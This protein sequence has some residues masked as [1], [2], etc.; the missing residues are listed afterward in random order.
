[1]LHVAKPFMPSSG[2]EGTEDKSDGLR[3]VRYGLEGAL[4]A[5]AIVSIVAWLSGTEIKHAY[6][7]AAGT[8]GFI[9]VL[10]IRYLAPRHL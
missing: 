5:T 2:T 10:L 4:A 9:G 8:V 7:I 6:D 1:M 3:G